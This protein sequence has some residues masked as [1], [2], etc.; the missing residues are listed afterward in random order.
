MILNFLSQYLSASAAP[1][2]VS[3]A[4]ISASSP[5]PGPI[6]GSFRL[7]IDYLPIQQLH[8]LSP[9][10]SQDLELIAS[11]APAPAPA[12]ANANANASMYEIMFQPS[13]EFAR[14]LLPSWGKYYTTNQEY[15]KETQDVVLNMRRYQERV[16][17][18][19]VPKGVRCEDVRAVWNEIHVPYF[20]EKYNYLEWGFL[21]PLNDSSL[22]LQCL[23]VG[24]ILSPVM[25]LLIPIL[26]FVLPFILLKIQGIPLTF[27]MYIKVL[28]DVAKN[29]FIGKAIVGIQSMSLEKLAYLVLMFVLYGMQIYQNITTCH[30][31]YLNTRE[32]NTK[33]VHLREFMEHSHTS[34]TAFLELHQHKGAYR[35]FC[36]DVR[37]H[38][39][40]L[41]EMY[42]GFGSI[43]PFGW[44]VTTLSNLGHM[45][46]IFHRFHSRPEYQET[47][48]YCVGFEGYM[49]NL[50][51]VYQHV[52]AG[53]I[54]T[55][56]WSGVARDLS[57]NECAPSV[58]F[59]H[60]YYPAL[61]RDPHVTSK[62]VKNM[63]ILDK[64]MII[65]GPNASGKTT[66]LK[67]TAINVILSQQLGCGFYGPRSTMPALYT[68]IHSYL[69]IPDTSERDSLFQAEA[70][71][72]KDIID[73]IQDDSGRERHFCIFDELYSGTNPQEATKAAYAF[74]KY[75]STKKHVD[76][77]LTTHYVAVCKRFRH[78]TR[79]RNHKMLVV[80]D[81]TT[82]QF[83]YT[84]RIKEGI[85]KIQGASQ[86]LE[87]MNYPAEI[88]GTMK[89]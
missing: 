72:C 14:H 73:S 59:Q 48:Q 55:L 33:L 10:I 61:I 47:L 83:Q 68:H 28:K 5:D 84:Y 7:P 45:L 54:S 11:P 2:D 1:K 27:D 57:N 3:A 74:L 39:Q 77:M 24:S 20:L 42:D 81:K 34:M 80:R 12:L 58:T 76:F 43:V 23:S 46:S 13:H 62:I 29:H 37:H 31:F 87:D 40:R 56:D 75:L 17:A 44:Q 21:K 8:A 19:G 41:H 16:S 4:D 67:T 15:L 70:R 89:Q 63:A 38:L 18:S 49:D 50:R 51:G 64:N 52:A 69:N 65:T 25:S 82:G 36:N 53:H 86:I 9:T 66:F 35:P 88:L 30:H 60:Q 26:F 79:I 22:F 6:H 32:M 78:S 71:R 85:S